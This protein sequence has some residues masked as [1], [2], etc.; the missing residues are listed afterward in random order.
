MY[1]MTNKNKH[2][3]QSP[4]WLALAQHHASM[5]DL[6]MR[7]LFDQNP[8]RKSAYSI[9]VGGLSLDYSRNRI[10]D[11]TIALLCDLAESSQ[12]GEKINQLFTGHPINT[13]EK[14]AVLHT[15]LRNAQ[16]STPE[17]QQSRRQLAD[18][19]NK[20][21]SGVWHGCTGKPIRH[22]VN[23]GIGGSHLGPK[24]AVAALKDFA[25][26]KLS[27][28]FIS[29]VDRAQ[30]SDVLNSIDPET[31]LFII[32]S[33]TFG[34]LETLTN[35]QTIF[36]WMKN[37][38]GA[39]VASKHFVAVTATP[40]K[41]TAFGIPAS[42]IFPIWEWVGGR[43]SIW[44]AISLPLMLMIGVE[45][46]N[47][48]LDG[49]YAMDQHF[50]TAPFASNMPVIMALLTIWYV[51]FFHAH[52]YAIAPYSYRLRHLIQYLQQA[53]M[54]SNGKCVSR[55]GKPIEYLT[56]PVIFGEEGC[57]GQHS[58]HQLLHQGQ[59]VIPLDI[60]LVEQAQKAHDEH[61]DIMLA[62]GLSQAQ[63]LMQGRTLSESMQELLNA[64]YS[65]SEAIHLAPHRIIPGNRPNNI[66]RLNPLNPKNLGTLLALYEHKIFASGIIWNINSFDQWGVELG[67][68]LLPD[69]LESLK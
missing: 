11:Q 41:A 44:S 53:E 63:A 17:I 38:F 1:T 56:C 27:F 18:F 54:E 43:Y 24:M 21:N 35:A 57:N 52:A 48:F 6:H 3:T 4:A 62:S 20:I 2:L 47:E 64:G 13:S 58:Y 34:T 68:Q 5:T 7:A 60:I 69:I 51:N 15:A 9:R 32:S 42:N 65:E 30:V 12:L 66:L 25:V 26:A 36:N 28:H 67:K 59:H 19:I 55:D 31:T 40:E 14:R 39:D 22:V 61:H 8:G 50:L 37:L 16:D 29:S 23:I 49:A 46:F 45:Q 33:K 10:N